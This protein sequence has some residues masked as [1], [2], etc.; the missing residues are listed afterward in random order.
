MQL[1][2]ALS[3][4]SICM[5]SSTMAYLQ[6][7]ASPCDP[8]P[9]PFE[10]SPA[11]CHRTGLCTRCAA[12][13]TAVTTSCIAM[14]VRI[15]AL[16]AGGGVSHFDHLGFKIQSMLHDCLVWLYLQRERR[17]ATVWVRCRV[18]LPCHLCGVAAVIPAARRHCWPPEVQQLQLLGWPT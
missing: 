14:N 17:A 11:T 7:V 3:W 18:L 16:G 6:Q 15:S 1:Q 5:P 12:P 2:H 10:I 8:A 13:A 9:R 4:G